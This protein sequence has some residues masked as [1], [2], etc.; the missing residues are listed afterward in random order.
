MKII[1]KTITQYLLARLHYI[2]VIL[3]IDVEFR[4]I[5]NHSYVMFLFEL[6]SNGYRV[7][8]DD[9]GGIVENVDDNGDA[10]DVNADIVSGGGENDAILLLLIL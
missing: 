8:T 9:I 3:I 10:Y 4:F 2:D 7:L 1:L 5:N 6:K